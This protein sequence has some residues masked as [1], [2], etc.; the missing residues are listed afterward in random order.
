MERHITAE[1]N[2]FDKQIQVA[3]A[4]KTTQNFATIFAHR[5]YSVQ[6]SFLNFHSYLRFFTVIRDSDVD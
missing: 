4:H 1:L 3:V 6:P 2:V 5:T